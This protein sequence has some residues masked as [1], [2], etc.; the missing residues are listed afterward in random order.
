M[1]KDPW[2]RR[3]GLVF[4]ILVDEEGE[5]QILCRQARLTDPF[6]NRSRSAIASRPMWQVLHVHHLSAPT[7]SAGRSYHRFD[8]RSTVWITWRRLDFLGFAIGT[9][10]FGAWRAAVTYRR[11]R[12]CISSPYRRANR[13]RHRNATSSKTGRSQEHETTCTIE[14]PTSN[15][16]AHAL[17]T[18]T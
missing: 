17:W 8:D 5:N 18:T 14:C 6:A 2:H 7:H 9:D 1:T 15:A 11:R 13:R 4:C 16:P 3:Y 12:V 10:S